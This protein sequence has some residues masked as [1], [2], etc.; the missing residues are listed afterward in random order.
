[1]ARLERHEEEVSLWKLDFVALAAWRVA[2]L[3]NVFQDLNSPKDSSFSPISS[4]F[5]KSSK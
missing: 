1:M 5:G 3:E 2:R 4:S